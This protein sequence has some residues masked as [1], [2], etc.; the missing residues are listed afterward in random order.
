MNHKWPRTVLH[1]R[2]VNETQQSR[3]VS[4]NWCPKIGKGCRMWK[5]EMI[6]T[7]FFFSLS[8]FLFFLFFVVESR[9][10]FHLMSSFSRLVRLLS[11]LRT[12]E[13]Q[14]KD[15]SNIISIWWGSQLLFFTFYLSRRGCTPSLGP[16]Q[17]GSQ[18]HA[19]HKYK[20][21]STQS[22]NT[23]ALLQSTGGE[24]ERK[25]EKESRV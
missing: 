9:F 17:G 24:R 7:F 20:H 12:R 13:Y 11:H 21:R 10:T 16:L 2:R 8:F 4:P 3:Q 6:Q 1:L 22:T 5:E 18:G 25:K 14:F 15:T 23:I 19:S